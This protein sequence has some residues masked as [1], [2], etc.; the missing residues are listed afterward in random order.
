MPNYHPNAPTLEIGSTLGNYRLL[1]QLGEGG[2]GIVFL[3]EDL[4]LGRRVAL[5]VMQPRV[6]SQQRIR[7]RFLRE[8]RTASL[9]EH[10]RIV[11]VYHVDEDRGIPFIAMELL[12][13]E[14]LDRYLSREPVPS[15][16]N[17]F[18]ITLHVAQ[19]L[20]IAHRKGLI[21]RDIKPSNIWMEKVESKSGF[22]CKLLDFGLAR[23]VQGDSISTHSGKLMG[24]PAYMSPE[25][26]HGKEVDHRSDL[27]SLGALMYQMMTSEPPFGSGPTLEIARAVAMDDPIPPIQINGRVPPLLS[28]LVIQ[29]LDKSKHRRPANAEEVIARLEAFAE[30]REPD[31]S[32]WTSIEF[33]MAADYFPETET[34]RNASTP[35]P[36]SAPPPCPTPSLKGADTLSLAPSSGMKYAILG[37]LLT[38]LVAGLS[39]LAFSI[40]NDRQREKEAADNQG[41]DR[42]KQAENVSKREGE[43]P[44]PLTIEREAEQKKKEEAAKQ[45]DLEKL[46]Q[47]LQAAQERKQ[48]EEELKSQL[49]R[50]QAET[51]L[52]RK[53]EESLKKQ[54]AQQ[55]QVE[56]NQKAKEQK[57]RDNIAELLRS[58]K[59]SLDAYEYERCIQ[60][61]TELLQFDPK[62]SLAYSYRAFAWEM[63]GD[64]EASLLDAEK[65]ITLAPNS[66]YALAMR[67]FVLSWERFPDIALEDANRAIKLDPKLGFAYSTRGSI[68]SYAY[69]E[70]GQQAREDCDRGI[71]LDPT[72]YAYCCRGDCYHRDNDLEK[73]IADYSYA[74]KIEPRFHYAFGRRGYAYRDQQHLTKAI[75]DF[76]KAIELTPKSPVAYA[77]R[78]HYFCSIGEFEKARRDAQKAIDLNPKLVDGYACRADANRGLNHMAEALADCEMGLKRDSKSVVLFQIRGNIAFDERRFEAAAEDFTR[79]IDLAHRPAYHYLDRAAARRELKKYDLALEDCNKAI[80][81]EPKN[82]AGYFSRAWVYSE[83]KLPDLALKDYGR[84]IELEPKNSEAF[85][86]RGQ[87]YIEKGQDRKALADANKAIECNPKNGLGYNVRGN[88]HIGLNE[89]DMAVD[90]YTKAIELLPNDPVIYRNRAEAYQLRDAEGDADRAQKDIEQAEKIEGTRKG[91]QNIF[92]D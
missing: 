66:A 15:L 14:S 11:R 59:Q 37:S 50:Q 84:I 52:V 33:G 55:Q 62:V 26:W 83:Q 38:I 77:D 81:L 67:A 64:H 22:R 31:A 87:I 46:Q 91:A 43:D 71:E 51:E 44:S 9:M 65:A 7:A 57:D 79:A 19:G 78:S 35:A 1:S 61:L 29:L 70:R 23:E 58:G 45:D 18:K 2:M 82:V 76:D 41:V 16:R 8:A 39:I 28:E 60:T 68:L 12:R 5:K 92:G 13:G 42:E 69:P 25:Q 72:G 75:A 80:E 73:A 20:A 63:L 88:A 85:S 74:I 54:L 3:A 32:R 36:R 17:C 90:D 56:G 49:D 48:R 4:K 21:H 10:E 34:P 53:R 89:Y 6:G 24:T 27:F 47:Q 30:Q 86:A 40:F